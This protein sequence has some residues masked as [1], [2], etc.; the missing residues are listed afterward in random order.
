MVTHAVTHA[1]KGVQLE[2]AMQS[3]TKR[4]ILLAKI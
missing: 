4:I 2:R 1:G 3:H